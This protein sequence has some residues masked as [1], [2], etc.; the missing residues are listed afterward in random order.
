MLPKYF[1][2]NKNQSTTGPKTPPRGAQEAPRGF[3]ETLILGDLE[4]NLRPDNQTCPEYTPEEPRIANQNAF[5]S[6]SKPDIHI[7][8]GGPAQ[9]VGRRCK[10]HQGAAKSLPRGHKRAP[11]SLHLGRPG[12]EFA[13][14]RPKNVHKI[15]PKNPEWPPKT[16]SVA[17]QNVIFTYEKKM[18]KQFNKKS[19]H[20]VKQQNTKWPGGMREAP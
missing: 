13:S 18:V 11:R 7:F 6:I 16:L 8:G 3:Q 14:R 5:R 9:D 2:S 1:T 20:K 12:A 15:R 4:R 17:F 19:K 10:R